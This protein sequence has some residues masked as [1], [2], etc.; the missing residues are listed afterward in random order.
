MPV[1]TPFEYLL[2]Q[3]I[4]VQPFSAVPPL[5]GPEL[6]HRPPAYLAKVNAKV[7]R[8]CRRVHGPAP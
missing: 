3:V 1:G 7:G 6:P 2:D 8:L 5:H 4:R